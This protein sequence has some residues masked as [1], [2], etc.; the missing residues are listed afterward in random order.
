LDV[1]HIEPPVTSA[2]SGPTVRDSYHHGDLRRALGDVGVELARHGGPEAVVLREAT[3]RVGV[4]PYAA[5][6]HFADRQAVRQA[7]CSAAIAMV[8]VGLHLSGGD[9]LFLWMEGLRGLFGQ[10]TTSELLAQVP[11]DDVR[12]AAGA[13]PG[14]DDVIELGGWVR[15]ILDGGRAVLLVDAPTDGGRWRVAPWWV[16]KNH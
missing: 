11:I 15:P 4:V 3:R 12:D 10:R 14:P 6:R 1:V 8:A 7:V 13:R 9:G 16:V 2:E 5:Y